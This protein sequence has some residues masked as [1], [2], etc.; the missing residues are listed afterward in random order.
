MRLA[1][2]RIVRRKTGSVNSVFII[3]AGM[4]EVW[5]KPVKIG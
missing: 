3:A 2:P 5:V 1:Q 4:A